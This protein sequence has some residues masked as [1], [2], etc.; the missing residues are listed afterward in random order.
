MVASPENPLLKILRRSRRSWAGEVN[1]VAEL[2]QTF[3][4]V[5][6]QIISASLQEIIRPQILMRA[7]TP[8]QVV[9]VHEWGVSHRHDRFPV[10]ARRLNAYLRHSLTRRLPRTIAAPLPLRPL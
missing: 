1:F 8:Q 6:P 3:D 10:N 5:L 4:V 9:T 7:T 2:L